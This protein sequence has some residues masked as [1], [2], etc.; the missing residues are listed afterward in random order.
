M[1]TKPNLTY[2]DNHVIFSSRW[3]VEDLKN[4]VQYQNED[5]KLDLSDEQVEELGN[6]VSD[7]VQKAIEDFMNAY[8]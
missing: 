1:E 3:T 8:F 7:S 5:S 2:S 4:A 6:M